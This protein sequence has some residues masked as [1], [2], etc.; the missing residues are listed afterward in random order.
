MH[1]AIDPVTSQRI[2]ND[3]YVDDLSTGGSP[4]EVHRFVGDENEDF[5]CNC[6]IPSIP[7]Q[8]SLLLNV[9]VPSGESNPLDCQVRW[10]DPRH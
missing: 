3:R 7:A 4:D 1:K 2:Q 8:S 5:Q 9:L 10:Q 6:T